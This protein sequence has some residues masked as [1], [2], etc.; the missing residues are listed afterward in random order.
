MLCIYICVYRVTD[1]V[2]VRAKALRH[3]DG[4]FT[5]LA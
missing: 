1:I 5:V 3:Y 4:A 2:Q